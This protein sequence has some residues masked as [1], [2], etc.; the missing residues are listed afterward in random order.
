[1]TTIDNK[2]G[3]TRNALLAPAG[4]ASASGS[5]SIGF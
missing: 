3:D 5:P 2:T 1:V 4:G